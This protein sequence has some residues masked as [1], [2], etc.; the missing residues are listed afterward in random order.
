M[1]RDAQVDGGRA[2]SGRHD[3]D[4]GDA[5]A[6]GAAA[7]GLVFV[8]RSRGSMRLVALDAAARALG[9]KNGMSLADARARSPTLAAV[10]ARPLEDARL[11]ADL[12]GWCERFSPMVALDPPDGLTLDVTGCAHLHGDEAG[13]RAAVLRDFAQLGFTAR[14][15][16]ASTPDA[17]R[18][19][20]RFCESDPGAIVDELEA[21]RALSVAALEAGPEVDVALLRA[22]LKTI[23]DLL[24]RPSR[25][26]AA[27][28]GLA[29]AGKLERLAGRE[30][31]RITPLRPEP[32]CVVGRRFAEPFLD[33]TGL[34][35]ALTPLIEEA[36]EILRARGQGG[37]RFEFVFYRVDG[38]ARGIVIESATPARD[39]QRL[40]RLFRL[41]QDKLADPLDPGFGFDAIGLHVSLVEEFFEATP[42]FDGRGGAD[43]SVAGL[44]DRLSARLGPGRVL[45]FEP[46]DAHKPERASQLG[47]AAG[48]IS[49]L[50]GR[51]GAKGLRKGGRRGGAAAVAAAQT[52]EEAEAWPALDDGPAPARPLRLF[53][54]PEPIETVALTPDEPP[55]RFRWRRVWRAVVK[56]EGPERI[57]SEWW[58][59]GEEA[60]TRDYYRLEDEDGRR[61]WV[62]REGLYERETTAPRWFLHG[63]FA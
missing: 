23:G 15:A 1:R 35:A 24:D 4:V 44:V 13:L 47:P 11:V 6:G 10:P 21:V 22:G 53:D 33:V 31:R 48:R 26:L 34:E 5:G 2:E 40:L 7:A 17:A 51:P 46:R 3:G 60:P 58:S 57:A 29:A 43:E 45:A 39:V 54:P 28:I 27:R 18:A 14:L 61:F 49:K 41:K 8:E 52:H 38:R 50:I 37:R 16:V 30:D 55:T 19:L 36:V 25:A 63:L 59:E 62:F 9:L 32:D 12:A 20:A 56:A 42:D